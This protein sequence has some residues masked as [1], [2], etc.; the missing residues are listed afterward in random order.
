MIFDSLIDHFVVH[1]FIIAPY[2]DR[3]VPS[4]VTR[5]HDIFDRHTHAPLCR[6]RTRLPLLLTA[7]FVQEI[8]WH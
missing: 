8:L 2:S 6:G 1:N 7:L 4:R 5:R 3:S